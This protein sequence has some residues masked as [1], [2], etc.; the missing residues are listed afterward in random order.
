MSE[1]DFKLLMGLVIGHFF[2]VRITQEPLCKDNEEEERSSLHILAEHGQTPTN[3]G[4]T[5]KCKI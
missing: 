5:D 2:A 1:Q 4:V 3:L